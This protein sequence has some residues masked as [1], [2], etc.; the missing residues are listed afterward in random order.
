[1][2]DIKLKLAE[3]VVR[4]RAACGAE[5]V[6]R[7]FPQQAGLDIHDGCVSDATE[8]WTGDQFEDW[9]GQLF[10]KYVAEDPTREDSLVALY[11]E[12]CSIMGRY[13][14]L[15]SQVVQDNL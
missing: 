10:D 4:C 13:T 8:K 9:A 15:F 11:R 1:M 5:A 12:I 3:V 6:S 7:G 2:D 14:P